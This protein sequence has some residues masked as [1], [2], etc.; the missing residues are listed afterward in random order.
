MQ[1]LVRLRV[2]EIAEVEV[3]EHVGRL[4]GAGVGGRRRLHGDAEAL[5]GD[6]GGVDG[7]WQVTGRSLAVSLAGCPLVA[8]GRK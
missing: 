8:A 1:R 5:G 4:V 6:D 2:G 3:A 7:H